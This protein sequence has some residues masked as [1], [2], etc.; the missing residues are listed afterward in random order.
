MSIITNLF[1]HFILG[2]HV[3]IM[4]GVH[5]YNT[6]DIPGFNAINISIELDWKL[7]IYEYTGW[8]TLVDKISNICIRANNRI[9]CGNENV[10]QCYH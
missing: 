4:I 7:Y 3:Y 6:K 1:S 2:R 9:V 10:T 8:E 5:T